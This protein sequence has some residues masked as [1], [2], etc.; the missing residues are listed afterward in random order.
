MD[1]LVVRFANY[2]I[3]FFPI[4]NMEKAKEAVSSLFEALFSLTD[5]RA[6]LREAKPSF[7]FT[8]AQKNNAKKSLETAKKAISKLE[9]FFE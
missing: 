9:K 8:D 2:Y 3:S 5:V 4:Q 7:K 6:I 1:P